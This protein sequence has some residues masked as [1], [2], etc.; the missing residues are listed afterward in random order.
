[1]S[2]RGGAG[3]DGPAPSRRLSSQH[4]SGSLTSSAAGYG[5]GGGEPSDQ[6]DVKMKGLFKSKPRTPS[7]LVRQTRDLFLYALGSI[8]LPDSKR[9]E[10]VYSLIKFVA[11]RFVH[12][13]FNWICHFAFFYFF[14][15]CRWRS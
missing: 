15:I 13:C 3:R 14:L 1:M 7:D 4:L 10:K 9:D 12:F 2:S 6:S 5:G 8:S 11:N